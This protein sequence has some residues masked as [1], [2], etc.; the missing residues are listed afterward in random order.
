MQTAPTPV[1]DNERRRYVAE[2]AYYIAEQR[3]FVGGSAEEDWFAAEAE[4]ERLLAPHRH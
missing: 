3:G 1:G 2:A 4:I